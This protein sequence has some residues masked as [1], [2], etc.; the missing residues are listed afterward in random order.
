M[1]GSGTIGGGRS[2]RV[3]FN[4]FNK[5][6]QPKD[7]WDNYDDDVAYPFTVSFRFPDGSSKDVPIQDKRDQVRISWK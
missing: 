6:N 4:T 2:C 5:Q 1:P 7:S 3:N